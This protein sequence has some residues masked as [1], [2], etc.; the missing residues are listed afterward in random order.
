M[1]LS[2][3]GLLIAGVLLTAV[4]LFVVTAWLKK[5]SDHYKK[6]VGATGKHDLKEALEKILSK[7]EGQ[8]ELSEQ[9]Q[10]QI[11]D[12]KKDVSFNIQK[13]G[14]LR[15][16]PFAETGGDHSFSL[17]LLDKH[18]TGVVITGLHSRDS[19]RIY[20]KPLTKGESSYNLSKEERQAVEKA[21]SGK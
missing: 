7:Q 20:T 11:D 5:T 10:K 9:L 2:G 13:V 4:W 17:A 16:N 1:L 19:T 12:L 18:N 21:I 6:L 8:E 14:L 3:Q 15:Y